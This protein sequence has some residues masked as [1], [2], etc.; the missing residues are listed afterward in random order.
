MKE[1]TVLLND[2]LLSLDKQML[3]LFL[4]CFLI[5]FAI[6]K[7]KTK[8]KSKTFGRIIATAKKLITAGP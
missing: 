6:M 4:F 8:K 3:F 2:S 5:S 1:G 7:P